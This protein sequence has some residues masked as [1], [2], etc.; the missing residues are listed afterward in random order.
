MQNNNLKMFKERGKIGIVTF[1]E[2]LLL[3]KNY[4]A[5]G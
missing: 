1:T 5:I 3:K 4:R 2:K